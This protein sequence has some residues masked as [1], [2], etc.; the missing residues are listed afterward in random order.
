MQ[1][2]KRKRTKRIAGFPV[3]PGGPRNTQRLAHQLRWHSYRLIQLMDQIS[4]REI[5]ELTVGD[6]GFMANLWEVSKLTGRLTRVV[7]SPPHQR[8]LALY[9]RERLPYW[10]PSGEAEKR[11]RFRA[12]ILDEDDD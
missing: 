5:A 8:R 7:H 12:S 11:L 1:R 9:I 3:R 6:L 4:A 10:K 2:R